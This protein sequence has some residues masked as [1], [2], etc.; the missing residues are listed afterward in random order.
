MITAAK[1]R[2]R[3]PKQQQQDFETCLVPGCQMPANTHGMCVKCYQT[4]KRNVLR[5]NTT[6]EEIVEEGLA[7]EPHGQSSL[8]M[9][10]IRKHREK[11]G[12][13]ARSKSDRRTARNKK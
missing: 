1:K 13:P 12:L 8:I 2:G 9:E 3:P 6:W 7:R 10:A 5:N 4:A 11:N